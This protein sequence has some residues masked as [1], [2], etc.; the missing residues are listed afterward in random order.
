MI[1]NPHNLAYDI[2]AAIG[3]VVALLLRVTVGVAA[4]LLGLAV[5]VAAVLVYGYA[6]PPSWIFHGVTFALLTGVWGLWEL[7]PAR[8]GGGGDG[9]AGPVGHRHAEGDRAR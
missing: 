4:G 3:V 8:A 9:V 7:R 2:A 1:G 6:H 5:S